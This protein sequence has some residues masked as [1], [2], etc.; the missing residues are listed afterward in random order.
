MRNTRRL[1]PAVAAE[2]REVDRTVARLNAI[3]TVRLASLPILAISALGSVATGPL[4][5]SV[6]ALVVG[7]GLV[8]ASWYARRDRG[9]LD[10]LLRDL[11]SHHAVEHAEAQKISFTAN[12]ATVGG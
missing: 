9:R 2:R 10:Y 6:V 8:L 1:D 12:S 11:E 7:A 3:R 4:L 5:F